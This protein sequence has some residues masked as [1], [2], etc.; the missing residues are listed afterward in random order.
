MRYGRETSGKVAAVEQSQLARQGQ[1]EGVKDDVGK[2]GG[3]IEALEENLVKLR[4]LLRDETS[5]V[6]DIKEVFSQGQM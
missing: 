6:A 3:S 5:S 2:A 1:I 4:E